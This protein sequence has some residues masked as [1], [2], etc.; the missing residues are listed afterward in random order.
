[1]LEDDVHLGAKEVFKS[2]GGILCTCLHPHHTH[3]NR[4]L[5]YIPG[6]NFTI[7]Y[8]S[9]TSEITYQY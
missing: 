5:Y 7:N 1:M 6:V 2:S 8:S 9:K 4:I 3:G